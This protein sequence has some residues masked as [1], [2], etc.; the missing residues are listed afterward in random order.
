[1]SRL[2]LV[3]ILILCGIGAVGAMCWPLLNSPIA[4]GRVANGKVIFCREHEVPATT[5]Q[6]MV[7]LDNGLGTVTVNMPSA[8][9]GQDLVLVETRSRITQRTKYIVRYYGKL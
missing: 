3:L 8:H 1:M 6:C 4:T 2:K 9:P 7:Q 5:N